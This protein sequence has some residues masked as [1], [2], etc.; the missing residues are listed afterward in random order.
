MRRVNL[1]SFQPFDARPD[2]LLSHLSLVK[3]RT[4]ASSILFV[5]GTDDDDRVLVVQSRLVYHRTPYR[6]QSNSPPR[7]TG[8]ASLFLL[9]PKLKSIAI[10]KLLLHSL[11]PSR[12]QLIVGRRW[13]I[14]SSAT[15]ASTA[16]R[17]SGD[18]ICRRRRLCVANGVSI[19]HKCEGKVAQKMT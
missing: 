11:E 13:A 10:E 1:S 8:S 9:F 17:P 14:E 16:P 2:W 19:M 3:M 6:I 15:A 12:A 7:Y 5:T 18:S 4:L